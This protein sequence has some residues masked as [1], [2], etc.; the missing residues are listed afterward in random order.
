MTNDPRARFHRPL[1]RGVLGRY[2][3]A[4]RN[5]R[6]WRLHLELRAQHV[7]FTGWQSENAAAQRELRQVVGAFV[8]DVAR[9]THASVVLL[10]AV[11]LVRKYPSSVTGVVFVGSVAY[12]VTWCG[13]VVVRIVRFA[14]HYR[15]AKASCRPHS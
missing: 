11:E 3:R 13:F 10:T 2:D 1:R 12:F 5:Y 4:V 6:R 9:Y 8:A 7:T 14:L 15:E